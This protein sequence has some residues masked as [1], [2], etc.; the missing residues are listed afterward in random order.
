[1]SSTQDRKWASTEIRLPGESAAP[2]NPFE[3][4]LSFLVARIRAGELQTGARLPP[5]RDLSEELSISRS[6]LRSVIRALQQAGYVHTRRGRSGGS[7]VVW[8]QADATVEEAWS[9]DMKHRLLDMLRFRSVLEPG[10]AALAARRK[11]TPEQRGRLDQ[12]LTAATTEGPEFRN[13]DAELHGYIAQLSGCRALE[14]GVA[15]IQL[16]LNQ[17]LLRVVPVMGPAVA[18]SHQQHARIV[19]AILQ[20]DAER[21]RRVMED[22]V[23]ATAELMRGFLR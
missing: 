16:M 17:S 7:F 5:E 23:G 20:S 15:N 8:T 22:H 1:M 13:R 11:L 3:E 2:R 6:T 18:H 4:T 12:L 19:D 9:V 21:A 10:G 14:E